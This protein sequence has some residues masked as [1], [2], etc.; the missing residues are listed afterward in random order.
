MIVTDS[1]IPDGG[2]GIKFNRADGEVLK[3]TRWR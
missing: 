3:W 1:H 2:Y